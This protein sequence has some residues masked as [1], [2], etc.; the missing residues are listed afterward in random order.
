MYS[1]IL[2]LTSALDGGGWLTQRAER[3]NPRKKPGTHFTEGWTVWAG[4]KNS[5][6]PEF[7]ARTVRSVASCF[8]G[9]RYASDVPLKNGYVSLTNAPFYSGLTV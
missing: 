1:F 4:A 7:D 2:S 6:P 5:A 9:L 8:T 3:I